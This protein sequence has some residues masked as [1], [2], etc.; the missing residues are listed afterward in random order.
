MSGATR[1]STAPCAGCRQNFYNGNNNLGV[2][3]C[4]NLKTAKLRTRFRIGTHT[5][6]DRAS[7]FQKVRAYHCH[8]PEGAVMYDE[9]PAHLR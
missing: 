2:K 7:N 6:Q 8:Q 4:W 3:E 9:L 1:K 5:P